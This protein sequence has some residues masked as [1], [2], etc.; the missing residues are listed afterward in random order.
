MFKLPLAAP[1]DLGP[2][3][4][5]GDEQADRQVH[6]GPDK[7]VHL[8]PSE[9]FAALARR[10]PARRLLLPG[11]I[12]ETFPPP[13]LAN[14]RPASATFSPWAGPPPDLPAPQ[15]CW[16]IDSRYGTEG[17]AAYIAERRD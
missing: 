8:Y 3:G 4:F 9:H 7:A 17:M 10:F 12:G 6:G 15:P 16:K 13:A 14:R 5:A 1:I 11:S 2:T